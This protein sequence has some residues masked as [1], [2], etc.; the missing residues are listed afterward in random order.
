MSQINLIRLGTALP[1]IE[2]LTG[3]FG[4]AVGVDA[5]HNV[6]ITG[7]TNEGIYVTG[8]P[9]TSTLNISMRS[10]FYGTFEFSHTA[11]AKSILTELQIT[12]RANAADMDGTGV[13]LRGQ[14]WY[15]DGVTPAAW[16]SGAGSIGWVAE[17]DATSAIA[18]HDSYFFVNTSLD[19]A[20]AEKLRVTSDGRLGL[21]TTA[22]DLQVEINSTTGEC[23]RLTFNDP[24]GTAPFHSDIT[25]TGA[26]DLWLSP[27]GGDV[28]VE[29][30]L[31][32]NT[33]A[34]DRQLEINHATGQCL[35]LTFND[36]DGAAAVYSDLTVTAGGILTLTPT[37]AQVTITNAGADDLITLTNA[38]AA[39]TVQIHSGGTSYFTGGNTYFTGGNVG[40]G[41]VAPI[42][43]FHLTGSFASTTSALHDVAA[44]TGITAAMLAANSVIKIQSAT[45]GSITLTADP[46]VALGTDGQIIILVCMNNTKSVKFVHGQG[47]ALAGGIDFLMGVGDTL[48]LMYVFDLALWIELFRNDT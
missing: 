2:T 3:N 20:V 11:A 13:A 26:G 38:A 12:N 14:L 33:S 37:S 21:N 41:I 32:I 9:G 42:A 5:A 29:G 10:P 46:Q 6:N 34:P 8:I 25:V 40:V 23:L 47:L 24:D 16:P 15:F 18:T 1:E 45:A 19:G 28:V 44:A 30:L 48:S 4:G 27:S 22:P 36:P 39:T 43:N 17:Q 31:G 35:R 7:L